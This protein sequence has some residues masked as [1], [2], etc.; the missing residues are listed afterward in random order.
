LWMLL[1]L[2]I[3]LGLGVP[4]LQ[5]IYNTFLN[6]TNGSWLN[7]AVSNATTSTPTG[8]YTVN[9]TAYTDP[10]LATF[11]FMPLLAALMALAFILWVLGG[12][13]QRRREAE[14]SK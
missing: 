14:G 1:S 6:T 2:L 8:T 12:A 4:I 5:L 11:Q 13:I 7:W 3:I 10:E 9:A